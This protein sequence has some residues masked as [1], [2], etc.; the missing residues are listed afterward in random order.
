MKENSSLSDLRRFECRI[1]VHHEP[2]LSGTLLEE[3][4]LIQTFNQSLSRASISASDFKASG[5]VKSI[6]SYSW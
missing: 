1:F 5:K 3:D 6:Y 2:D 4:A